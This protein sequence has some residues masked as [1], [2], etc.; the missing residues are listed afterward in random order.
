MNTHSSMIHIICV[1]RNYELCRQKISAWLYSNVSTRQPSLIGSSETFS[2]PQG[3]ATR[4]QQS[5][6]AAVTRS[7]YRTWSSKELK[8]GLFVL[9]CEIS[10]GAIHHWRR[11]RYKGY[12]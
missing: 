10:V 1:V 5:V 4:A 2:I 8:L 6:K 9:G 7:P 11:M 12:H 3:Q